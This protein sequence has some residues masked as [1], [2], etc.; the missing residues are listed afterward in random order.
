[1][2]QTVWR[3]GAIGV[4]LVGRHLWQPRGAAAKRMETLYRFSDF[5]GS[6]LNGERM[7]SKGKFIGLLSEEEETLRHQEILKSL[8]GAA[9]VG[10]SPSLDVFKGQVHIVKSF[11]EEE[12]IWQPVFSF[13]YVRLF[14]VISELG[15]PRNSE[16]ARSF[17]YIRTFADEL[18]VQI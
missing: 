4:G 18:G 17:S 6:N 3:R 15:G 1:M 11:E 9:G 16:G 5:S 2:Q 8:S 13:F 12:G 10:S 14:E 7:I